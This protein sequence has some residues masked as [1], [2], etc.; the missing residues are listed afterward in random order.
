MPITGINVI[1]SA[2]LQKPKSRPPSILAWGGRQARCQITD[3][4]YVLPTGTVLKC[5]V[6]GWV[7]VAWLQLARKD[8]AQ[9]H[10]KVVLDGWGCWRKKRNNV[11]EKRQM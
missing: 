2:S 3:N 5:S 6:L 11:Y 7:E 4:K 9:M 10:Q 8:V 1:I